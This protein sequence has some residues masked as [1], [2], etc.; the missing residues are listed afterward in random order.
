MMAGE[1]LRLVIDPGHGG[2]DPGAV[3]AATNLREADVALR[4]AHVL[5]AIAD[6]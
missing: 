6:T 4:V 5:K 2:E 1:K 3:H